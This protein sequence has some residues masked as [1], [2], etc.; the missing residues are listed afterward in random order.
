MSYTLTVHIEVR[1]TRH[2]DSNG[3]TTP[4][5]AAHVWMSLKNK[6]IRMRP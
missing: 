3:K 4:S 2:T 1:G 6:M 5:T